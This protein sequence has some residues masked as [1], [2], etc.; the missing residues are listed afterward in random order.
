MQGVSTKVQDI[1]QQVHRNEKK[2]KSG[3]GGGLA[4]FKK[5]CRPPR[6]LN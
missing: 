2:K 6:L 3:V 1:A 4:I 5:K